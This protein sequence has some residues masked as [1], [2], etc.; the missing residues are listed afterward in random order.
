[1]KADLISIIMPAYNMEK[2]IG[3]SIASIISQTYANWELIIV[4]D[5]S[6]DATKDICKKYTEAD[7]RIK[8]MYEENGKQ[9]KARN[10]GI[11]AAKGEL[12]AFLDADDLW[13][14]EFLEKQIEFLENTNADLV[15]SNIEYIDAS[16][17]LMN[18]IHEIEF[19]ELKGREGIVIMLTKNPVPLSTVMVWKKAILHVGGFR[20]SKNLQHGEDY[21]LWF[22]LLIHGFVLKGNRESLVFY[23]KHAGQSTAINDSKYFQRMDIIRSIPVSQNLEI[24][25]R[26]ALSMW[27][28]RKL[29]FSKK[30]SKQ[31]LLFD[32]DY[33]PTAFKKGASKIACQ[34]FP[35]S[36]SRKIMCYISGL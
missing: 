35:A 30:A 36:F 7:A 6:E 1:M 14:N 15:F 33:M 11:A 26:K 12:I 20:E 28:L 21:E 16:S 5:G 17:A 3:E 32:A 9:G 8:Y 24:E 25:K 13:K 23:R 2:F 27:M 22:Q 34:L 29:I 18:D 31:E 10:T 4:D 19:D